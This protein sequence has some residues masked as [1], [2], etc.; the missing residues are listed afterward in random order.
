MA[1]GYRTLCCFYLCLLPVTAA[2]KMQYFADQ[3]VFVITFSRAG[4]DNKSFKVTDIDS[5]FAG[6]AGA[7]YD[8][9]VQ[10]QQATQQALCL[11]ANSTAAPCGESATDQCSDGRQCAAQDAIS[12]S[13][14]RTTGKREIDGS[15]YYDVS[16]ESPVRKT[17]RVATHGPRSF[18]CIGQ[19]GTSTSC[20]SLPAGNELPFHNH[21]AERQGVC[22][23]RKESDK[24]LEHRFKDDEGHS[25]QLP[26]DTQELRTIWP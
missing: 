10:R 7:D 5:T 25:G 21:S 12:E 23:L 13:T 8:L 1:I 4:E 20:V 22:L 19:P 24:A 17:H 26:H 9:Q 16:I 18:S 11:S 2:E 15:T 14:D 3:Q 6:F